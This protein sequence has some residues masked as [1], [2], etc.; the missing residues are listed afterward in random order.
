MEPPAKRTRTD[1][2]PPADS[3]IVTFRV[4]GERF[5]ILEQTIRAKGDT[6]LA[7][8]LDDPQVAPAR[9][10]IIVEGNKE[11][12]RYIL[13]W[14]RY[15]SILLPKTIGLSE[16]KRECAFFQLPDDVR[17]TQERPSLVQSSAWYE[18]A[19]NKLEQDCVDQIKCAEDR[20]EEAKIDLALAKVM[21][22]LL[23]KLR[24]STLSGKQVLSGG[25][26]ADVTMSTMEV[27]S[28]SPVPIVRLAH[29]ATDLV[30]DQ[31]LWVDV[32]F[33]HA[34]NPGKQVLHFILKVGAPGPQEIR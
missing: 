10:E 31:G 29:R 8:M 17:I 6:L 26:V 3:G 12:F 7:T 16:M 15:G 30:K 28:S 9:Q 1:S 5:E 2:S 25:C 22:T 27:V 14:Y 18:E 11:R 32:K 34:N 23:S 21:R 20:M 24:K 33:L 13:D 19:I 4:D